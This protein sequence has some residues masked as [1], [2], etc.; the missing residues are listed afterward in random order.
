M[1]KMN[2]NFNKILGTDPFIK[3]RKDFKQSF[4]LLIGNVFWRFGAGGAAGSMIT[5]HA[6]NSIPYTHSLLKGS[7]KGETLLFI[8][9]AAW[10][11]DTDKKVI[12]SS[13]DSNAKNKPMQNGLKLLMNRFIKKI[14]ISEPSLDFA[15]EFQGKLF[16]KVFCNQTNDMQNYSLTLKD[17]IYVVQAK[18]NITLTKIKNSTEAY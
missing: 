5:L 2:S 16:L 10:R 17:Q 7:V 13:E 1:N 12:C 9:G 18:S 8:R 14:I 3:I 4:N 15:I 6:G 11:I